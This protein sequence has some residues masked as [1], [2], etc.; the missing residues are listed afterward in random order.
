MSNDAF[1]SELSYQVS[2]S[3]AEALLQLGILTNDE[4][5]RAKT[6][7]LETYHPLIG[8]VLAEVGWLSPR[9]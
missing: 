4:F 1:D 8:L 2:L 5:A 7:L 9:Y 6:L 3:I